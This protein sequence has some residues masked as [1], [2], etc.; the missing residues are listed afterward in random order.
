[1]FGFYDI[2]GTITWGNP[3]FLIFN[4]FRIFLAILFSNFCLLCEVVI[5]YSH[6]QTNVVG[7]V[8]ERRES[9]DTVLLL[10]AQAK[11]PFAENSGKQFQSSASSINN[12]NKTGKKKVL[13]P[14]Q[15]QC[16]IN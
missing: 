6:L 16:F 14:M 2:Q 10:F 15:E 9:V 11:D 8:K 4:S 1:M 13:A 12:C 5:K 3:P 7:P